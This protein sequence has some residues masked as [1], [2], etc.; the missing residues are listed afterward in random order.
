MIGAPDLLQSAVQ[1]ERAGKQGVSEADL[2]DIVRRGPA[3]GSD[4]RD[5]F[6]PGIQVA[7]GVP[8]GDGLAGGAAGG[9]DAHHLAHGHGQ[10]LEGV[11]LPQLGFGC[12]GDF[13]NVLQCANIRWLYARLD[14]LVM[15]HG[16]MVVGVLYA[17]FEPFQLDRFDFASLCAFDLRVPDRHGKT[18]LPYCLFPRR[19]PFLLGYLA[20]LAERRAVVL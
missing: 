12:Q 15:I 19:R 8:G 6:R 9:V 20:T 11:L 5:A 7:P 1:P 14:H 4:A 13:G 2:S 10:Q 17:P 18:L 3:C 16:H